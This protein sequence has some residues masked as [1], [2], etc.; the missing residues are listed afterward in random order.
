[1]QQYHPSDSQKRQRFNCRAC[2]KTGIHVVPHRVL[3]PAGTPKIGDARINIYKLA[4]HG[5]NPAEIASRLNISSGTA[6]YHLDRLEREGVI[7]I[8]NERPRRYRPGDLRAMEGHLHPDGVGTHAHR[9]KIPVQGNFDNYERARQRGRRVWLNNNYQSILE[10]RGLVL[11]LTSRNIIVTLSQLG[12]RVEEANALAFA[13]VNAVRDAFHAEF[14]V[15]LGDPIEV[16]KPDCLPTNKHI[17]AKT[18]QTKLDPN[19]PTGPAQKRPERTQKPY[20]VRF[21]EIGVD[22]SPE[23][24]TLE[25]KNAEYANN[26]RVL[27]SEMEDVKSRVAAVESRDDAE[28]LP[29][30]LAAI[31]AIRQELKLHRNSIDAMAQVSIEIASTNTSTQ[32]ELGIVSN[33]INRMS[34]NVSELVRVVRQLTEKIET[35]EY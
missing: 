28:I 8:A 23:P 26:T 20:P 12:D 35:R 27:L 14:D 25:T 24:G 11:Q 15:T 7:Q 17:Y 3:Q 30:V 29:G 1:V 18:Y 2:K 34:N 9:W 31:E 10:F 16:V 19:A 21:N 5:L 13:D 33:N 22:D 32:N 4:I 6:R